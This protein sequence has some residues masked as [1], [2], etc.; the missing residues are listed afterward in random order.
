MIEEPEVAPVINESVVIYDDVSQTESDD[1]HSNISSDESSQP[2][3]IPSEEIDYDSLSD[4]DYIELTAYI[5]NIFVDMK[6]ATTDNITKK[7]IY[8]FK[9]AYLRYGTAKK[10]K[11]AAE[12][13]ER[14]DLY[15]MIWDSYRPTQAQFA[16]WEAVPD[17]QYIANP[18][19]GH[20][21][22]TLGCGVDI[23]LTDKDGNLI[24][25]PTGFDEFSP[26]AHRTYTQ[27]SQTSRE[28]ALLL[29]NI[30][31]RHGFN[32]YKYEWWHYTDSNLQM[33]RENPGEEFVPP[34]T[35]TKITVSAVGDCILANGF[36]FD[37]Q[38]S[39]EYYKRELKKPDEYF[40]SGVSDIF[41][42]S[43]LNIAN[44]EN[45]FTTH[46]QRVD[47]A[48]QGNR[49]FWFK[50][51]PAYARI[52]KSGGIHAVNI[53]NNHIMDY[54]EKGYEDTKK[55]LTQADIKYFGKD[56]IAFA[57]IKGVKIALTGYNTLGDYEEGADTNL[58]LEKIKTDLE[59][60]KKE[61]DIQIVS[62]HWGIEYEPQYNK[63]Q[64][65]YAITAIEAG[66]DLILGH[67]PHILQEVKSYKNV[68]IVYSLGN[69][70]YGGSKNSRE[71]DTIIFQTTFS[72]DINNTLIN[73]KY[74]KIPAKIQTQE[75]LNDYRPKAEIN[76][77]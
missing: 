73:T 58:I 37:Y 33:Y 46:N 50:S 14:E 60:A 72:L 55:A 76:N 24:E 15:L 2:E 40:F 6:Y 7:E 41:A 35:V 57:E 44:L 28:N 65:L 1:F 32:A 74:K 10:L 22:H 8:D 45:A 31:I 21:S 67:H 18:N 49:A 23:T 5:P 66:A 4:F 43:H 42:Q 9:K 12:E 26:K 47:K 64:E 34:D 68:P 52:L 30:M 62:F 38:D 3:I 39:F 71:K 59:K 11:K 77:N 27:I 63:E 48:H 36:G 56:D 17:E 69:F 29:E 75:G 25:M 61:S 16:L 54:G 53:A 19:K 13:L 70:V 20:N 51:N